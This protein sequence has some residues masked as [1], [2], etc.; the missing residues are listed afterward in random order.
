MGLFTK[1][2]DEA[3][4]PPATAPP[5][6]PKPAESSGRA[7][8]A[9]GG[10]APPPPPAKAAAAPGAGLK[11][12]KS[13]PLKK[14]QAEERFQ[15][16]HELKSVIHR[17]LVDQ[18]DM[19]KLGTD[20]SEELRDQVRR[21][22]LALCE[23]EDT[24]LNASERQRLA[25]EILD[26]TF[27]LGPLETLLADPK[28][29]DI[30][31]NGPRRIYVERGGRL[32]LT[33]VKFKDDGHLLHIIDKIVSPLGRR[34]DEVSPMV[35]ARLKDG[36]RVN[37]I[38]PPLAIDGPSM[39]IRRFGSNP[40]TWEDYVNY[41]SCAPEMIEFF[42]ACVHSG[43]NVLIAGGT[44]SGKTT[45]LNNLSAFIPD[46]ER[47]VTIEDAAELQLRQPHVVRLET[48]PPNLEGK[49]RVTI[50]DLL[51]NSLRMRPDRIVVGECRGGETLDMLQ[52]MNTGHEGSMTTVHANNTRDCVQRVETM[53]M[54]SGIELPQKAIRQQFAS[55]LDLIIQAARLT[56]GR[57]K[58]ISV[59]E[60]QGM[61]GDVVVMQDIFRFEQ[62]GVDA[63]GK[64][65]GRIVSTGVR[66]L[67]MDRL[68]THGAKVEPELF[69][70]RNL[71]ADYE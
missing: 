68:I 4:A 16:F 32:T 8:S 64:A 11:P 54:M 70:P 51:V 27:G 55:A 56:G 35:D 53:V 26:E 62:D 61:E 22:V 5:P 12:A 60:V 42:E 13:S 17:K 18:L 33:D 48:R 59:T 63:E 58:I 49:G 52:A 47:I 50:R 3:P 1:K 19:T 71:V 6:P 46:D 2:T 31:I 45:L 39:S 38:I 9:A 41:K 10:A 7:T 43:L 30:L 25:Q 57:R 69:Q 66:P 44:G 20:A 40:V 15:K 34:C 65:H 67:F 21:V 29:S 37:A 36:S 14:M 23:E 24:L 28:I